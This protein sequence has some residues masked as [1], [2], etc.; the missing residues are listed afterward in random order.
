MIIELTLSTIFLALLVLL[1]N[2]LNFWM[3]TG[4]HVML[5]VLLL[6]IFTVFAA[7]I[8]RENTKD[9][10]EVLH[11]FI[12]NR[13]AFLGGMAV[14]VA[15]SIIQSLEHRVDIWVIIALVVM[16]VAKFVGLLYSRLKH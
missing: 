16:V 8:F 5:I 4:T 7:F 3:P 15:A 10:R 6:V 2:P 12:A 1:L 13:F 9:E 14:L 11:R